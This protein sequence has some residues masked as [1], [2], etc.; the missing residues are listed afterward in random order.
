MKA[1]SI[2]CITL[3]LTL[4]SA[5]AIGWAQDEA[6]GQNPP[7]KVAVTTDAQAAATPSS[8]SVEATTTAKATTNTSMAPGDSHVRIV[9]LSEAQGTL[10]MD[11]GTGK[12]YE[13][14][15]QNMPIV[16]GARLQTDDGYAEVEFEDGSTMRLTPDSRV[17]FP[18]LV[19]HSNGTKAS[20]VKV[21]RGTVYV[22]LEN[23]K[24]IEFTLK[25]G[26]ATMTIPPST[27]MRVEIE[28]PKMVLSVFSGNV[29][30]QSGGTT[31]TVGKKESATLDATDAAKINVTKKIAEATY[32]GW[33]KQQVDYHKRYAKG[34]AFAGG[35]YGYG[36]SD[37]NYYGSFINTGCGSMWQPYLVSSA[38]DPYGNG[39]WAY[40]PGA[41]YSWVSP[42]PWGWLP[43]HSGSWAFCPGAGWGW[44]PGNNWRGLANGV[45]VTTAQPL[46]G[47]AGRDP[48]TYAGGPRP[49]GPPRPPVTARSTLVIEN[50]TP[51]VVSREN[52]PGNFVFQRDSAGMGVPRGS[53]GE[54]RGIS[55]DAVHH[56]FANRQVYAEPMGAAGTPDHPTHHVPMALRQGSP[57]DHGSQQQGNWSHQGGNNQPGGPHDHGASAAQGGQPHQGGGGN[58]GGNG[59]GGPSRTGGVPQSGPGPGAPSGASSPAGPT[60]S[61]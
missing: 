30:V 59:S 23:S 57:E 52:Q 16:E 39:A 19:L 27:H 47:K 61:R 33:D 35:G 58:W 13:P 46:P 8:T 2:S 5:P 34:N 14:T 28:W 45:N 54:L 22:N 9:R 37:L 41:G 7:E 44:Q 29:A 17:E 11:R 15:M 42:Y 25:A 36:I 10:A 24:D 26:Q 48:A 1:S 12:G 55:N 43:Y 21:E 3:T 49:G 56:G 51:L 53:L 6:S 50:R 20:T 40:Y 60:K 32:D 31:T 4:L 38:W 18:Q